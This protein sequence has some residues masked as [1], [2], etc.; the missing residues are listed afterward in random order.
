MQAEQHHIHRQVLFQMREHL[1]AQALI[2]GAG[3]DA[4]RLGESAQTLDQSIA[5]F[6]RTAPRDPERR[7]EQ[8]DLVGMPAPALDEEPVLPPG[9]ADLLEFVPHWI[10][11]TAQERWDIRARATLAEKT[12]RQSTR[13][14]YT[15]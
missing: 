9:F 1:V 8:G 5:V 13:L 10:G 6:L 2:G 14:N 7:G 12:D 11:E 4:G 15:H 3:G